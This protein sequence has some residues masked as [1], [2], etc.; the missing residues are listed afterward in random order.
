MKVWKLSVWVASFRYR[1]LVTICTRWSS[2][3][4]KR[5]HCLWNNNRL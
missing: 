4:D 5:D 2:S 1:K 3:S